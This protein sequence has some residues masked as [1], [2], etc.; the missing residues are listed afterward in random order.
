MEVGPH[1]RDAVGLATA[2]EFKI[3][4]IGECGAERNIGGMREDAV[5]RARREIRRLVHDGLGWIDLAEQA[6]NVILRAVPFDSSCWHPVDPST[7][8]YTGYFAQNL[9]DEPRLPHYEYALADVNKW[10]WLALSGRSV[11]VLSQATNGDLEISPRWRD[12]MRPRGI[13]HE[14]RMAFTDSGNT[15]GVGG[16]YRGVARPD[17]D[18]E[19]VRLIR[20]LSPLIAEGMRRAVLMTAMSSSDSVRGPGVVVVD[21]NGQLESVSESAAAMMAGAGGPGPGQG[22]A[23]DNDGRRAGAP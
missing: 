7:L 20:A 17:F 22:L 2:H 13:Q 3:W 19:E 12:L 5:G 16:M 6:H 21:R 11:G 23:D 10:A 8:L 14:L 15:W 9:D 1:S 18:A 4:G